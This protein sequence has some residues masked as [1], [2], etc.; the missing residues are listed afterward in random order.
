[1]SISYNKLWKLLIDKGMKKK[2]LRDGVEMSSNTLA[3][4]GRNEYVAMDVLVR[5]CEFLD[6]NIG[7]I[8]EVVNE[9]QGRA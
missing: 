1:M 5:I 9:K 7:D 6:C 4:M 8:V 3:K 2:D